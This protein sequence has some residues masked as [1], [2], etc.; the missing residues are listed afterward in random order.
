MQTTTAFVIVVATFSVIV[1]C[2]I[3]HGASS[4]TG[5]TMSIDLAPIANNDLKVLTR[6]SRNVIIPLV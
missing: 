5:N 2:A 1:Q 3:M 6:F 4:V